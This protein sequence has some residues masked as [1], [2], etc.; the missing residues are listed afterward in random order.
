M[1]KEKISK[2]RNIIYSSLASSILGTSILSSG[3]ASVP[4]VYSSSNQN[5]P[6]FVG[7][8]NNSGATVGISFSFYNLNDLG[9]AIGSYF[10]GFFRPLRKEFWTSSDSESWA[11]PFYG[12]NYAKDQRAEVAGDDSRYLL[13]IGGLVKI[14]SKSGGSGGSD[15]GA[16][17]LPYTYPADSKP[18]DEPKPIIKPIPDPNPDPQPTGGYNPGTGGSVGQ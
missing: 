14:L 5:N 18:S 9:E 15:S 1:T 17:D 11:A 8:V 12:R 3:C 10:N 7:N 16:N 13:L 6:T 2:I 4:R